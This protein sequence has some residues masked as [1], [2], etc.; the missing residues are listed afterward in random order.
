MRIRMVGLGRTGANV[1][2]RLTHTFAEKMIL[3][4]G[5]KFGGRVE[6]SVPEHAEAGE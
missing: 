6:P 4:M 3:A 2:R 5:Q 1:V